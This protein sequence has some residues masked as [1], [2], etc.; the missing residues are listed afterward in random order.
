MVPLS[1][2]SGIS[3]GPSVALECAA[4]YFWLSFVRGKAARYAV[5]SACRLGF[6]WLK[7]LDDYLV[8]QPGALDAA[9]GT[10]FIGQKLS[11][12]VTQRELLDSYR[13]ASPDL[14]PVRQHG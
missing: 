12:P 4:L 14:H 5:R 10:Y 6:F 3:Q 1:P 9:M 8:Q 2:D 7:Y 13:G 11:Q